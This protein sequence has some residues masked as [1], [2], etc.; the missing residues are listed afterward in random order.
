MS[1]LDFTQMPVLTCFCFL[2][3]PYLV[4]ED[5]LVESLSGQ[6]LWDA[7]V[8]AVS[9]KQ[10]GVPQKSSMIDAYRVEYKGWGSRFVEWVK[11]DRVVEPN[12]NNRSLQ[13][14]LLEERALSRSGLPTSLNQMFAKDYILAR[15]RARGTLAPPDF[16]RIA[17]LDGDPSSNEK[18]FAMMKAALL[19][20]EAA[21][22][23]GCI[24]TRDSGPWR[25]DLAMQW[26]L[27]VAN[28][29]GPAELMRCTIMLEDIISE[30]WMK[31][32]VGHIRSCLPARWKAVAEASPSALA[33]RITL[34]D[35][36]IK[37][38]NIDKKRFS[39]RKYKRKSNK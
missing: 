29:G 24:D 34:L 16:A 7:S 31:E 8:T 13:E 26:R 18:T 12:E 3:Q 11:P 15:D 22:P 14:E 35:R 20:I 36:A 23:I 39:K 30:E 37:Y 32:N 21:L 2:A 33:L 19:A 17:Q 38:G 6:M 10:I 27:V 4:G 28:A 25:A 5:V 1:R 9:N